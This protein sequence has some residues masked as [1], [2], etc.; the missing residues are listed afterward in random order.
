LLFTEP[1]FL[2]LFL[3]L[4]LALYFATSFTGSTG[5]QEHGAYGNW[6]LL[7]ASVIFTPRAADRSPG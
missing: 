1:T 3:P 4:L 6:L 5:S 7:I 2:F